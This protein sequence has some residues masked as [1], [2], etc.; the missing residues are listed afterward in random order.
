MLLNIITVLYSLK[1][2]PENVTEEI[3]IT[4]SN[5]AAA[6]TTTATATTNSALTELAKQVDEHHTFT[7][8]C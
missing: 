3:V 6:T 2:L 4:L 5:K 8:V 7:F 1:K